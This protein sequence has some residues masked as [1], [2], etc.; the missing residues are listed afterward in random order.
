MVFEHTLIKY[1]NNGFWID[2][3]FIEI[4][5]EFICNEIE[6]KEIIE[7]KIGVQEIYDSLDGNR[8]GEKIGMVNIPLN[9]QIKTVD[10]EVELLCILENVKTTLKGKGEKIEIAELNEI[11]HRKTDDYFKIVWN[12]PIY[13]SSLLAT[14]DM[15][16]K[17]LRGDLQSNH[18]IWYRGFGA[19]DGAEEL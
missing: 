18:T 12:K 16:I 11:E 4:L 9:R 14:I 1:R 13:I 7:Y 8:S 10:E 3:P 6:K 5:S 15:L 2:Q 19:P 17:L